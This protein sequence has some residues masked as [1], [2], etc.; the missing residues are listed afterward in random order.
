VVVGAD[1][2]ELFER[3]TR[4]YGLTLVQFNALDLVTRVHPEPQEPWQLAQLLAIGSNHITMVL[5]RLEEQEL[6]TRGPHP[7]DRRRR[8][9]RVTPDGKRL[10]E[11]IRK[12]LA[13]VEA[14]LVDAALRPDEQRELERLA[15][16]LRHAMRERVIPVG[17]V[18]PGP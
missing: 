15:A 1:L 17:S 18:R 8:L 14:Q 4:R 12:S 16:Q 10:A 6:V 7:H 5:D 3:L 13:E 9:V 2:A 11:R